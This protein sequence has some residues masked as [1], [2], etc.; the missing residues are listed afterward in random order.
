MKPEVQEKV[1]QVL[2]RKTDLTLAAAKKEA[3]LHPSTAKKKKSLS[4]DEPGGYLDFLHDVKAYAFKRFEKYQES[5][6][7]GFLTYELDENE[8]RLTLKLRGNL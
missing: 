7:E 8:Q 6:I 4:R 3:G 2:A 1:A 5:E